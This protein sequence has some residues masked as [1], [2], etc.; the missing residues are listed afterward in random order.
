MFTDGDRGPAP[1]WFL[2]TDSTSCRALVI[3]AGM[4]LAANFWRSAGVNSLL[5]FATATG[6]ASFSPK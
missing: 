3:Q 5:I 4:L 1:M 2:E 6:L